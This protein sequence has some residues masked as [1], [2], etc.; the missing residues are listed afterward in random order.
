MLVRALQNHYS[1]C[2]L[3]FQCN[4]LASAP[5]EFNVLVAGET[6]RHP[7]VE[8]LLV[9]GDSRTEVMKRALGWLVQASSPSVP[10]S[11]RAKHGN[12]LSLDGRE[13]M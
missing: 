2:N 7:E 12:L 6:K 1:P 9:P 10:M 11:L 13:F 8:A 5:L 4:S 3:V